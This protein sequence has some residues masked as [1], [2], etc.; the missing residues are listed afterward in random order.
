MRIAFTIGILTLFL[1]GGAFLL[2]AARC[3]QGG[4]VSPPPVAAFAANAVN[5]FGVRLLT[6]L[7]RDE[8]GNVVISPLS[9]SQAL[10][11]TYNGAS[12]TT[13]DGMAKALGVQGMD[14]KVL[15][16]SQAALLETLT[17]A[18]PKVE[19]RVAN[20]LWA[21]E[22]FAFK[23]DFLQRNKLFYGAPVTVT[24][25]TGAARGRRRSTTG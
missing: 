12:G 22:G 6:E 10:S 25:V 1:A 5:D 23:Q 8:K 2:R 11:M 20:A 4:T 14:L 16:N 7:A 13:K 15:N 18:D 9:L 3:Q 24:D 19:T 17:S 21:Q